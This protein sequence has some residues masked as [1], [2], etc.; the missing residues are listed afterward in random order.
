MVARKPNPNR[1]SPWDHN[2]RSLRNDVHNIDELLPRPQIGLD[3]RIDFFLHRAVK[4]SVRIDHAPD[5]NAAK[6]IGGRIASV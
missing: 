2:G 3:L 1:L 6:R 4:V 5:E